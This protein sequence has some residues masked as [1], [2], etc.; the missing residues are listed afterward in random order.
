MDTAGAV[1]LLCDK[2][3]HFFDHFYLRYITVPELTDT[4]AYKL[5]HYSFHDLEA[6]ATKGCRLCH[7][8][9]HSFED[10][11]T[12]RQELHERWSSV[13]ST[14]GFTS[15]S[16]GSLKYSCG[17]VLQWGEEWTTAKYASVGAMSPYGMR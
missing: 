5:E 1:I 15:L 10:R 11:G 3:Q 16:T 14:L 9:V 6:Q 17:L 13:K 4:P 12:S 8:F 7:Y 2:C